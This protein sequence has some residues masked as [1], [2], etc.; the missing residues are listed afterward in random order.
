MLF[1]KMAAH[2][3]AITEGE[4]FANKN[5]N[6]SKFVSDRSF[7][8]LFH[9]C[10]S[11]KTISVLFLSVVGCNKMIVVVMLRLELVCFFKDLRVL[12]FKPRKNGFKKIK[13]NKVL[14]EKK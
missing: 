3:E 5:L 2:L 12:K 1:L 9:C 13:D 6:C 4:K 14:R 10:L 7:I 11:Y 8:Y